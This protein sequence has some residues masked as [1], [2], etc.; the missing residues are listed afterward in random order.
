MDAPLW[1]PSR[2]RIE[3]A[4]LTRFRQIVLSRWGVSTATYGDLHRFSTDR[5][6]E[7]WQ[8]LWEFGGV[9]G[10]PGSTVVRDVDQMP[11]ARFF[12]DARL[13]FAENLLRRRDAESA[14]IFWGEDRVRRT[15]THAE[16]FGSVSRCAQALRHAGVGPGDRVAGYL[17]SLPETIISVLATATIGAVWS[18]ASPDFGVQGVVDRFSQIAPKVLIAAD[19]Y[20]YGGKTHDGLARLPAIVA[21]LPTAHRE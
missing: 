15:M 12:P 9:V 17:P 16:L 2:A 4:Q 7:F 11:G 5:P 21:A 6:E 18:S 8:A 20:F 3:R 14:I 10:D 1:E 19:G 13:N